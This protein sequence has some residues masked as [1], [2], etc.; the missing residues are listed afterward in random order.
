M[1]E[2]ESL[3]QH[4]AYKDGGKLLTPRLRPPRY[5]HRLIIYMRRRIA[6]RQAYYCIDMRGMS[7]YISVGQN[8]VSVVGGESLSRQIC[9]WDS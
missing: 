4:E 5:Y 8:M 6:T 1:D 7:T 9:C 3:E 2:S